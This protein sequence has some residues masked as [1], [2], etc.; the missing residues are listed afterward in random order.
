MRSIFLIAATW[1][2]LGGSVSEAQVTPFAF[3]KN[4][5]SQPPVPRLIYSAYFTDWG[6]TTYRS[7]A[8]MSRSTYRVSTAGVV[9]GDL[10]I[11]AGTID[12]FS[13]PVW[14]NPIFPGFTQ[15]AQTYYGDDGETYIIA[16]KIANNEPA[17]YS[18]IYPSGTASAST[19][20]TLIAVSGAHQTSPINATK[21]T[22][23][24]STNISPVTGNSTGVTTTVA[25]TTLIYVQ[26]VDWQYSPGTATFTTPTGFTNILQIGDKGNSS[27]EWGSQQIAYKFHSAIGATGAIS[28]GQQFSSTSGGSSWT[29]ILAIAPP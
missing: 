17:T 18:G 1:F 11:V 21:I 14:P 27:W 13:S 16:W 25:N 19:C 8:G 6:G 22:N 15:L 5:S 7:N 9:N 26:G 4:T 3:W 24:G 28:G 23:G 10:L 29:A 2:V 12:S 20:L